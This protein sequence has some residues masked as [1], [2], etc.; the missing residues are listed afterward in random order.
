MN[1]SYTVLL[2]RPWIN[3]NA[4]SPPR[5]I[6][7]SSIHYEEHMGPLWRIMIRSQPSRPIMS[8]LGF[9]KW[10]G[11]ENRT[12]QTSPSRSLSGIPWPDLLAHWLH[13]SMEWSIHITSSNYPKKGWAEKPIIFHTL[14]DMDSRKK[15]KNEPNPSINGSIP[16]VNAPSKLICFANEQRKTF[17]G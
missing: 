10:T 1:T 13:S 14:G 7:S 2:G 17:V 12:A 5:T 15:Y 9:I 3:K 8:S 16:K 4:P 6:S 11:K